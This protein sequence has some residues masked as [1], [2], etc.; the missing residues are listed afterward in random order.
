MYVYGAVVTFDGCN[1]YSNTAVDDVRHLPLSMAPMEVV[2]R[3]CPSRSQG[4]GV[5]INGGQ[6]DFSGCSIFDNE[7]EY[8]R[9]CPNRI[10]WPRWK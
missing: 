9:E 1:I 5:Y 6:V 3:K 7:A 8:V 4:G 10:P 2:S